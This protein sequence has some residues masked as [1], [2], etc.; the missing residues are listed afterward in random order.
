MGLRAAA[1]GRGLVSDV[2]GAEH[3]G[4]AAPIRPA[5]TVVVMRDGPDGPEVLLTQRPTTMAFG[6]GLHVFPGGALDPADSEPRVLARLRTG[7]AEPASHTDAHMVAAIRELFEEAGVLLATPRGAAARTSEALEAA[8]VGAPTPASAMTSGESFV[9]AVIASDLELRGDLLVP[10]SRWVTPPVVARRFDARFFV[11][12]LP[13]GAVPAFDPGEVV[14]HAWMTPRDALAAMADGR[15]SLWPPTSTTL[16]QLTAA[17]G[18]EDVRRYLTPI[19]VGGAAP[20]PRDD[21][22]AVA[23]RVD[24]PAV[25]VTRVRAD[26]AGGIDGQVVNTYLVGERRVVVVDPGDPGD[27]AIDRL[28]QL[29][30]HRGGRITAV[31]LTAPVPEH[32]AGVESLALRL[33]V[34]ILAGSGSR[35]LLASSVEPIAG[36]ETLDLADVPI[37]I[38]ATPGTH[39]DHLAFE[40]PVADAVLVGDLEGP[41]AGRAIPEPVDELQL[42]RSRASVRRLDRTTHLAAH[43]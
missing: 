34:P 40:V 18:I 32:A 42:V 39:P 22:V 17:R 5:S 24:R 35:R 21:A 20:T 15:I 37:V 31:L 33:R 3:P 29:V 25:A 41:R 38:H 27:A 6:P 12:Q 9:D 16:Q 1:G 10:L 8:L 28:L 2:S 13:L 43:D 23:E 26:G 14:G 30:A 7:G 19:R 11:A 36:G 4:T